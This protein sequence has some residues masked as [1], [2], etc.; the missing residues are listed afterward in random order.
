MERSV[1]TTVY[2]AGEAGL[3]TGNIFRLWPGGGVESFPTASIYALA[4]FVNFLDGLV[5]G[6]ALGRPWMSL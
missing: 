5:L 2:V 3:S 1:V 4:A 6:L